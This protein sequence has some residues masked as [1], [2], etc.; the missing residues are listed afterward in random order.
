MTDP[1]VGASSVPHINPA[2]R[3][4]DATDATGERG[5]RLR[6]ATRRRREHAHRLG[7]RPDREV[8]H[9]VAGRRLRR[10]T[11]TV[12]AATPARNA[13]LGVGRHAHHPVARR[14]AAVLGGHGAELHVAGQALTSAS[15]ADTLA[16][17]ASFPVIS[18]RVTTPA[19]TAAGTVLTNTAAVTART[20][21]P[22]LPNNTST[23]TATGHDGRGPRCVQDPL[24]AVDRGAGHHLDRRRRQQRPVG[25]RSARSPWSTRC[26]SARPW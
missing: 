20:Y 14:P 19:T 15:G 8:A 2:C 22:L 24:G 7:R 17:G 26:R 12:A 25:A 3:R 9:R 5:R 6:S 23:D 4:L 16:S 10:S 13:G 1:G 18:V 11:W 21:D